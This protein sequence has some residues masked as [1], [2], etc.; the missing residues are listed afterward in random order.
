MEEYGK[1]GRDLT[2]RVYLNHRRS[3]ASADC[4]DERGGLADSLARVA[5]GTWKGYVFGRR[6]NRRSCELRIM[7][8]RVLKV[9]RFW[10]SIL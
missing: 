4:C 6:D 10:R 5:R 1:R 2:E 8:L 7:V 9:L 3:S